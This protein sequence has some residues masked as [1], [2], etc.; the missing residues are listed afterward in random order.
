MESSTASRLR[1]RKVQ[2]VACLASLAIVAGNEVCQR[3]VVRGAIENHWAYG[4]LSDLFAVPF[5]TTLSTSLTGPR[6]R[7]GLLPFLFA[8]MYTLL[9]LEGYRDAL[10]V[11]C[12]WAGAALAYPVVRTSSGD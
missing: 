5:A 9:E 8:V 11:V 10:D 2:V 1:Y 12:Y 3:L 4:Y 7:N 6:P